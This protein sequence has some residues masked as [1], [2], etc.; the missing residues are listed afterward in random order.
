MVD[1]GCVENRAE[2]KKPIAQPEGGHAAAEIA[3]EER[4]EVRSR[5]E[6]ANSE[7]A[8]AQLRKTASETK[9][10]AAAASD[11]ASRVSQNLETIAAAVEQLNA[12][13]REIAQNSSEM[14]R[15]SREACDRMSAAQAT[16]EDLAKANDEIDE[17][18]R[19]ITAI[20]Q[21]TNLLALNAT[22]EAAR[23]G[24]FGKGFAVVAHE[25]KEL[26]KESARSTDD[27]AQRINLIRT[28]SA[29]TIEAIREVT[30]L[31]QE[32][33][34]MAGTIAAAVEEQSASTREIGRSVAESAERA[35]AIAGNVAKIAE[36]VYT[37]ER[38][39]ERLALPTGLSMN[40]SD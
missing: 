12:A 34:D 3:G 37:T 23:A 15:A 21:Q 25:V 32:V 20:A 39:C 2:P 5:W 27:I 40:V 16:L 4:S 22:I 10:Q 17:V 38:Q 19:V 30:D 26:A 33:S 14:A 13:I 8:L 29:R 31:I 36:G 18:I 11:D 24:E 9:Q 28:C 6:Q 35:A 1:L 7:R